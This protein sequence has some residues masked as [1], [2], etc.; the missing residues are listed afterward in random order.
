MHEQSKRPWFSHYTDRLQVFRGDPP[1]TKIRAL[2]IIELAD[3]VRAA[4]RLLQ[5]VAV[6]V[7]AHYLQALAG[8]FKVT[9][10]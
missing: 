5:V 9:F 1:A 2:W 8:W 4:I 7:L 3:T 10:W 6:G